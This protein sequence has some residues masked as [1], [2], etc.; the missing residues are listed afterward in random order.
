MMSSPMKS[1]FKGLGGSGVPREE[2]S[3]ARIFD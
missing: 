3:Y 2:T 1:N